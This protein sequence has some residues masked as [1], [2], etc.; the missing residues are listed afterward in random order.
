MSQEN[1]EIV[2]RWVAFYNRR[3]L[4]GLR[5]LTDPDLKAVTRFVAM[6]SEVRGHAGLLA[7]FESLDDAYEYFQLVP[8]DFIDAGAAVVVVARVSWC[9]KESGAQGETAVAAAFWLRAGK[10][11]RTKTFTDRQEALEAV[12]L[13]EQDVHADS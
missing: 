12:G 11:L 8:S 4:D 3:D 13:S 1:V 7:Y 5:G 9:G 10:V 6:E 2:Q